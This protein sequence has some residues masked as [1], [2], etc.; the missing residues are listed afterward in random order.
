[1]SQARYLA[2]EGTEGVGKS[3]LCGL[4][5]SR[6]EERGI[7]VVRVREPGGTPLG[8]RIREVLL[9][10]EDMAGWTEALLFAAQRSELM[11]Q[12][13]RP[14]LTD[15]KWVVSDRCLYSSLAY[16]GCARHLGV[17]PV[18][19]INSPALGGTLPDLVVWLETDPR[20]ALSR[21][22]GQ[23][24]IGASDVSVHLRVWEGYRRLW[25]SDPA[26]ML[27]ID[28]ARPPEGNAAL[29]VSYLEERGWMDNS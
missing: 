6:L 17:G 21:Q 25:A 18:R 28:A 10:G 26:R 19:S 9:H 11:A 2:L 1:M 23:D 20:I 4:L 3:T 15:G 5:A 13:V 24:R 8:D 22:E 27:R 12:V 16:Q 29:L 14:A 7:E